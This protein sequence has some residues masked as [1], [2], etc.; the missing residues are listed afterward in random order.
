MKAKGFLIL[1]CSILVSASAWARYPLA[2]EVQPAPPV[3]VTLPQALLDQ[4][5]AQFPKAQ[6]VTQKDYCAGFAAI[7]LPYLSGNTGEW[8]YSAISGDFNGDAQNDYAVIVRNNKA[9]QVL[10]ALRIAGAQREQYAFT[11]LGEPSFPRDL[12]NPGPNRSKRVA[13]SGAVCDG[14]LTLIPPNGLQETVDENVASDTPATVMKSLNV[15]DAIGFQGEVLGAYYYYVDGKWQK[16]GPGPI[17]SRV[18]ED[19]VEE[20]QSGT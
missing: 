10:A 7:R 13:V 9:L 17:F 5:A 6:V 3:S 18:G 12:I 14:I 1:L 20:F 11:Q 4:L 16:T 8:N 19:E 2:E 15:T